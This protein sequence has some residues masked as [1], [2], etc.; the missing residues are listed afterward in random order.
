VPTCKRTHTWAK[1]H[2][3][4]HAHAR[5]HTHAHT[6]THTHAHTQAGSK[7]THLRHRQ[8]CC[9]QQ[10][11]RLVAQGREAIGEADVEQDHA[12]EGHQD[13]NDQRPACASTHA[14][15]VWS[16]RANVQRRA[17]AC[18]PC[19]ARAASLQPGGAPA[20]NTALQARA[21]LW[22]A[23]TPRAQPCGP[24]ARRHRASLVCHTGTRHMGVV[25]RRHTRAHGHSPVP[26]QAHACTWPL[27]SASTGT[28]VHTATHQCL[29]RHTRAHGH[30]PVPPL[31][32]R[33]RLWVALLHHPTVRS[34]APLLRS[35]L[36]ILIL[37]AAAPRAAQVVAWPVVHERQNIL[38]GHLRGN[39]GG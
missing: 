13:A 11:P 14:R 31:C 25:A 7:G 5:T 26:P 6:H 23:Q 38:R 1:T 37:A 20:R 8:V 39:G 2:T 15:A 17:C 22:H 10:R 19:G 35:L 32:A 16:P 24:Q 12:D 33:L 3:H 9:W 34:L 30:S 27:T 29:H 4:T 21:G 36:L 18:L 28:R